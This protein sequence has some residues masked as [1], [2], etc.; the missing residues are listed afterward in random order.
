[1]SL[2]FKQI[3]VYT[4]LVLLVIVAVAIAAVLF[5]NRGNSVQVWFF[6]L[7]DE[8]SEINVVWL[9]V[10]T[11]IGAIISWWVLKTAFGLAKDM[12]ELRRDEEIRDRAKVQEDMAA[13]LRDQ[14]RRIDEKLGQAVA[15]DVDAKK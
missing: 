13:K 3:K 4:K 14:E 5:K 11:A 6:G 2:A 1:M 12:R 10:W 8:K 15:E 7:V 9:M